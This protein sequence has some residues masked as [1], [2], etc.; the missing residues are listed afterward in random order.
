MTP[1]FT[2]CLQCDDRPGL[3]AQVATFLAERGCN[4]V[5]AQ[6]FDDPENNRFFMRVCFRSS[7]GEGIESLRTG[8]AD[9]A[10]RHG[11][12]W[13]IRDQAERQ[14]I[15]IMVSKF[16][17]CLADLLYRYRIGE[18]PMEVVAV[19]S[20][21]PASPV[22]ASLLDTIPYHHLPVT[23]ETKASQEA[24]IKAIV[25]ET[26]A[27]LVVLARYMQ[28]LSDDLSTFLSGRCI[29]IHHSFLPG[30]K[31]AK[32]YHQAHSRGVKMIGA[33]AHYVTGDLDEGPIIHQDVETVTHADTAEDMVRKGRDIERRVLAEAVLAHLEGRVFLNQS[34]TV[35]FRS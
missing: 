2:L 22:T 19:I 27:D 3:V 8:F 24:R 28:V 26:G 29:N 18:M 12:D 20:N 30:F 7:D 16:D 21:H 6:Q 17:H 4:I 33:T 11:M 32:P 10:T 35:V 13:S 5:E 14:K 15:V 25:R 23:K 34:R 9:V 1:H 31:G